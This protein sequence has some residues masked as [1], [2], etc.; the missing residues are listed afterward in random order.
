MRRRILGIA[1]SAAVVLVVY[2]FVIP[3]IADVSAVRRHISSMTALELGVLLAVAAVF[4]AT[5]IAS[6]HRSESALRP[7]TEPLPAL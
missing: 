5:R 1:A 3:Q 6:I 2:L 7:E 4:T